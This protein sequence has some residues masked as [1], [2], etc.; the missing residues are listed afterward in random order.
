MNEVDSQACVVGPESSEGK[1]NTGV[2][3]ASLPPC[4]LEYVALSV[5]TPCPYGGHADATPPSR[6]EHREETVGG[7]QKKN[8]E[9][10]E[11]NNSLVN[12]MLLFVL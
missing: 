3:T 10:R 1:A 12:L 2:R 4:G 9:Q 11:K 6:C 5:Y 8:I 7:R